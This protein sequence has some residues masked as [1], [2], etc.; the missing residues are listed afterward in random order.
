MAAAA[1]LVVRSGVMTRVA[2]STVPLQGDARMPR[3]LAIRGALLVL[4]GLVEG[5]LVLFAFRIP[6]LTMHELVV[7]LAVYMLVDGGVAF[8]EAAGALPRRA[9]WLA[10]AGNAIVSLAAGLGIFVMGA[11][12]GLRIFGVWAIV[13]GFLDVLQ[14]PPPTQQQDPSLC[15]AA[16]RPNLPH[17]TIPEHSKTMC[18]RAP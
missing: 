3:G 14:G 9:A 10:P 7:V 8:V 15:S 18:G 5:T 13:A 1:G 12:Q 4:L 6:N 11:P 16:I 17:T 2:A